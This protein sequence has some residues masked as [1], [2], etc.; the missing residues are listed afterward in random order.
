[1]QVNQFLKDLTER[2]SNAL[3]EHLQTI[4]KDWEKNAQ[5]ILNA[6]FNK[7]EIITREEFDAQTKV[8]ARTRQKITALETRIAEL[9]KTSKQKKSK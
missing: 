6:A 1:M 8:L 4:K 2:L 9:E 3:P 7:L 5:S